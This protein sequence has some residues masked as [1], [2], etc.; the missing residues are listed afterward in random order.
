MPTTIVTDTPTA[1]PITFAGLGVAT[2]IENFTG[3][4]IPGV[5]V[6]RVDTRSMVQDELLRCEVYLSGGDYL[7]AQ[8]IQLPQPAAWGVDFGPFVLATGA[9]VHQ[10][11]EAGVAQHRGAAPYCH[12]VTREGRP[13]RNPTRDP[14]GFCHWHRVKYAPRIVTGT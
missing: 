12:G 11:Y 4:P 2:I 10:R 6:V 3:T 1:T 7:V 5:M 13:C 9:A 8:E 14:S